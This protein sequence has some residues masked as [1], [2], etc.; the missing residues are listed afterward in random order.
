M[1][2]FDYTIGDFEVFVNAAEH[3]AVVFDHAKGEIG[4]FEG[5]SA[6]VDARRLA[7][8]QYLNRVHS[9]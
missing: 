4:R 6:W 2:E 3:K 1:W 5:S 9:A 7:D 8:E